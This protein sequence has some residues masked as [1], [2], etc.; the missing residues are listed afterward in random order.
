MVHGRNYADY[1]SDEN[2]DD[3]A[4]ADDNDDDNGV[5]VAL[6]NGPIL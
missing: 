3:G 6:Y 2:A 5:V 1:R 4:S